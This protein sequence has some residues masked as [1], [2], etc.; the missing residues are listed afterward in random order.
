MTDRAERHR[1]SA[2]WLPLIIL[3]ALW[4]A[5]AAG[6]GT[7]G[8]E[9]SDYLVAI[10]D[11]PDLPGVTVRTVETGTRL[12]LINESGFAVEV[13]GY[14]GEPYAEVRPEG[15]FLN[16]MSPAA[17][18]NETGDTRSAP[19]AFAS[20]AAT[21][22]WLKASDEPRL[23]W[24]D[25]RAG[26]M[27][28]EPPPRV[29]DDP[30]TRHRV[31]EWTIPLRVGTTQHYVH[32]YVDWMPPPDTS[33]WTAG[34]LLLAGGVTVAALTRFG[35]RLVPA[36]TAIAGA[37]AVVDA[38]GRASVAADYDDSWPMVLVTA[39]VWPTLAG[40]SGIVAAWYWWAGKPHADLACALAG[41]TM[42]LLAGAAR[43][44]GFVSA[45]TPTPWTGDMSRTLIL[46]ATGVGAGV[47]AAFAIGTR[48]PGVAD[49]AVKGAM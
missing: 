3:F 33:V 44:A 17:Y 31:V 1:R 5:P 10:T 46:L 13:L 36:L 22:Q 6:H 39:Q 27:S 2:R 32:G 35:R 14:A 45:V 16:R 34:T 15:V 8:L 30:H 11:A 18:L 43:F 41:I 20:P 25:H 29:R 7:A 23:R 21:P 49:D 4:P 26:W 38:V 9:E 37:G 48:R 42:A 12:E 24:H 28:V 40:L 19:P 47:S